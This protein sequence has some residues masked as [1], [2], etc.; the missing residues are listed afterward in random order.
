[1]TAETEEMTF[2]EAFAELEQIVGRLEKGQLTLEE[3]L[4]FF[5][6]G[7]ALA[8]TCNQK[9]DEAELKVEETTPQGDKPF[10]LEG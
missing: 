6:R 8:A 1:M 5:E 4:R 9:L 2:E 10:K 7:Q 3:S